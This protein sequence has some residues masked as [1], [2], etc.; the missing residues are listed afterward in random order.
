M[1]KKW[2]AINLLL[3]ALA[4][5]L[6]WQLRKSILQFNR[7]NDL[8]KIQ[9]AA[10]LKQRAARERPSPGMQQA[11][12]YDPAEFS[13]ISEKNLF[14][15]TRSMDP[16]SGTVQ[17]VDSLPLAQK[18]ILVGITIMDNQRTASIID[19]S[20][21]GRGRRARI[22]RVGDVYQGYTITEIS[23]EQIVL[24]NGNRREI[25]PLREGSKRAQGGKTAILAT[26]VVP[27]GASSAGAANAPV[28]IGGTVPAVPA[29]RAREGAEAAPVVIQQG[30]T[31]T[32][33]PGIIQARKPQPATPTPGQPSQPDQNQPP[34]GVRTPPALQTQPSGTDSQ[35]RRVIRTPFGDILRPNR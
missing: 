31:Q 22:T 27:I 25:I 14:S 34:T 1:T 16:D 26:R 17:P 20:S 10:S 13:I 12:A 30:T 2:I 15:D 19:P 24:E 35:G 5:L 8:S 23:E 21:Q 11:G 29:A 9:P 7:E 3:L 33:V 18:P 28:V 6:G 32:I 4:A